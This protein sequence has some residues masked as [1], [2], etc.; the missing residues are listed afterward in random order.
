M[1]DAKRFTLSSA[2]GTS[3]QGRHWAAAAPRATLALVHGFGE[4][5]GRYQPMADALTAAGVQV[6][7]ADLRGHGESD[8]KRGV[9]SGYDDFRADLAALLDRARDLHA[10]VDGPLVLFGHSMGGG[11][12]LDYGVH[13]GVHSGA[14]GVDAVIASAPLVALADAPPKPLEAI[15]RGLA[16]IAPRLALAQPIDGTK[17]SSLPEEQSA[18]E[19]DPLTHGKLGLRTAVGMVDTGASITRNAAQC[20]L[21]LL[22]YHSPGDQ[23]TDYAASRAACEAAGGRFETFEGVEHEMHNDTGREDVYALIL[24]FIDGLSGKDTA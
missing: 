10:G 1:T 16:K 12:V 5:A 22:V 9:V 8:G 4:H 14:P 18:Y 19:D 23:L 24:G 13:S 2:D 6:V 11:I 20:T 3:L 17:I 21:P 15:M 7:A